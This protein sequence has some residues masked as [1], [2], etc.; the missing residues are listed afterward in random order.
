MLYTEANIKGDMAKCRDAI[1]N[2]KW[3]ELQSLV[4]AI[5]AKARRALEVGEIAV[6]KASDQTY[7]V[8][9][10]AAVRRLERGE[11]TT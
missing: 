7:K 2:R 9:L 10:S 8:T 1:Q 11:L 3:E 6:E 5:A 4:Q